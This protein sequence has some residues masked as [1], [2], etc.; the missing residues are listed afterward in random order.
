MKNLFY[1]AALA[2]LFCSNAS[3]A[4]TVAIR[5]KQIIDG[6]SDKPIAASVLLVKDHRII[7]LGGKEIIPAGAEVIDLSGYTVMPGMIDLHLHPLADGDNGYQLKHLQNSS[8]SKAMTGL[9]NMQAVLHQGWTAVRIPGDIDVGYAHLDVRNAINKGMF[10]GPHVYGAGHWISNTGGGGDLNFFS[11]EQDGVKVDGLIV[12]NADEM[13][14]AVRTEIKYGSDWIKLLVSGAYMTA[15]DN[16]RN[17]HFSNDELQV[18]MEEATKRDVPVMAHAHSAEAIKM[19]VKAGARTIEHG[20]FIDDEGIELLRK[21][22]TYLVPTRSIFTW[23]LE[24]HADSKDHA[25]AVSIMKDNQTQIEAGLAKAV[26]AGVKVVVGT[27]LTGNQAYY[28]VREFQELVKAGMTNMQA[29]KAGTSLA[30][31]AL[32]KQNE[33]GTLEQGKLADLIAIDGDPSADITQL[34]NVKFV[35]IGGKVVRNDRLATR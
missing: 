16:P 2:G 31:E 27:D 32:G 15:G 22:G 12:D 28:H 17:V 26:K 29:I 18:A 20:T 21:S 9:K 6:K 7:A 14:K 23:M 13:R 19:S 35:M 5:C 10:D 4:Q 33:F 30:A 25:K 34:K 24:Q 1:C 8:A 3:F 11:Y